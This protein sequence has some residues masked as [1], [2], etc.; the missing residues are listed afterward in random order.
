MRALLKKKRWL[1]I[2]SA[3]ACPADRGGDA[4]PAQK[5]PPARPWPISG[6]PRRLQFRPGR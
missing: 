1:Y 3:R 2:R 6:T 4:A 5:L